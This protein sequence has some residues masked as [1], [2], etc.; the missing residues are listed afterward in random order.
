MKLWVGLTD[1]DW[2]NRLRGLRPDEVNF[3]QPSGS[4]TFRALQPG[5]P[6]LFKLHSPNNFIVGG[7]LFVRYSVLP[8]SLV[9]D[10]FLEKNGVS[11]LQD[12]RTRVYRYRRDDG[13]V[14]PEIGCNVLVEPFFL[15]RAAWIPTPQS[16]SRNIVQG[17]TYDTATGEGR[18]LWVRIT[19]HREQGFQT[20]V[21]A[22]CGRA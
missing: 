2:F 7:G 3:W 10:T 11:S 17:K 15:D 22:N 6:F 14:D 21:N 16:W 1:E 13:S 9:W 19:V 18:G 4:R 20:N 5:E 12:L 8:T